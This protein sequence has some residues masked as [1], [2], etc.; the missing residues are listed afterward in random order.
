MMENNYL[1][2]KGRPLVRCGSEMYYGSMSDMYIIFIKELATK[3]INDID[4]GTKFEIQLR[5]T[6]P[7]IK[8][9]GKIVKSIERAS[10]ADS[11]EL[12]EAWLNR[13]NAQK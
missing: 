5:F 10:F 2:Y 3:K 13:A 11:L 8:G 6:D 1:C 4:V 7:D 9:K 12:A